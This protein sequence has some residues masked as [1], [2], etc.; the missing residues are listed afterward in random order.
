MPSETEFDPTREQRPKIAI[1]SSREIPDAQQNSFFDPEI[2]GRAFSPEEIY[3]P[4]TDEVL[5]FVIAAHEIGHLVKEGER[6][7]AK[8]DNFKAVQIEERRAWEKGWPYL[9]KYLADYFSDEN[10]T[11]C[12]AKIQVAFRNIEKLMLLATKLSKEIYVQKETLDDLTDEEYAKF[13]HNQ[14][15]KL[16][17]AKGEKFQAIFDEIKKEKNGVKPNWDRLSA[18]VTKAVQDI[19]TD[20]DKVEYN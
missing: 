11:H 16:F 12:I 8:L 20:N 14:L 10:G 7:D 6:M 4:D 15:E 13:R 19:L 1:R 18:V 9:Q 2:W 17:L 3:L 5:S